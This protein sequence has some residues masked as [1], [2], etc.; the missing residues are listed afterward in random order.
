MDLRF[1][2]PRRPKTQNPSPQDQEERLIP[3]QENLPFAPN[4]FASYNKQV[5][6][7]L[8]PFGSFTFGLLRQPLVRT[9]MTHY[10]LVIPPGARAEQR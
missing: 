10:W 7:S 3:Y 2:D 9:H 6:I 1:V 4:S 8:M 5:S